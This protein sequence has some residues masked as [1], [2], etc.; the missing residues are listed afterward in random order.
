MKKIVDC[1]KPSRPNSNLTI[2][3]LM[4]S[5]TNLPLTKWTPIMMASS[6]EQN[7]M[8]WRMSD[9]KMINP[10]DNLKSPWTRLIPIQKSKNSQNKIKKNK[11]LRLKKKMKTWVVL[12]RNQVNYLRHMLKKEK[13]RKMGRSRS[14]R[15]IRT[16]KIWS[17]RALRTPTIWVVRTMRQVKVKHKKMM[18]LLKMT[19]IWKSWEAKLWTLIE[20][21]KIRMK[22]HMTSDSDS[23]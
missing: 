7:T 20:I 6:I 13:L 17:L 10:R 18:V 12:C 8:R 15:S 4:G 3:K 2:Q 23:D 11:T 1:C 21:M 5:W 9:C 19:Q 14:N 16:G 22:T